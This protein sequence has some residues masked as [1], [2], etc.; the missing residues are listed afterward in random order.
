MSDAAFERDRALHLLKL[1]AAIT[2]F[3]NANIDDE[4]A[5]IRALV[6]E[7]NEAT[8]YLTLAEVSEILDDLNASQYAR[9]LVETV[10]H[11]RVVK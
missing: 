8:R 1:S 7:V 6:T 10:A 5:K 3:E 9:A 2:G 4:T 11:L